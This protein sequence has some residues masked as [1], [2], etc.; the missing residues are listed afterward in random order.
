MSLYNDE[1]TV[2]RHAEGTYVKGVWQEGKLINITRINASVQPVSGRDMMTLPEGQMQKIRFKI[3]TE[4]PYEFALSDIIK[5]KDNMY[6]VIF[7]NNWSEAPFLNHT[8]VYIGDI[9]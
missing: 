2:Y 1:I 8:K 5:Y 3:Y 6:K 4:N 9:Q 7:D